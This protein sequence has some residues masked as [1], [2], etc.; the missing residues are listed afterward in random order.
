M[1]FRRRGSLWV[2]HAVADIDD[3]FGADCRGERCSACGR[4]AQASSAMAIGAATCMRPMQAVAGRHRC[5]GRWSAALSGGG[6]TFVGVGAEALA[7]RRRRGLL[8]RRRRRR[9]SRRRVS[10]EVQRALTSSLTEAASSGAGFGRTDGRMGVQKQMIGAVAVMTDDL[11]K[12]ANTGHKNQDCM[13]VWVRSEMGNDRSRMKVGLSVTEEEDSP[14]VAA[15]INIGLWLRRI[16]NGLVAAIMMSGLDLSNGGLTMVGSDGRR[17]GFVVDA[18]DGWLGKRGGGEGEGDVVAMPVAGSGSGCEQR[19]RRRWRRRRQ[20]WLR[21]F[22]KMV[23]HRI[24]AL[25]VHYVP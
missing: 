8:C 10:T 3:V 6:V 2:S 22:M 19:R 16:W 25:P 11:I 4:R 7:G 20:P 15:V 9:W 23:E 1:L 17:R 13:M 21:P 12:S 5:Q 24:G 18:N 14:R